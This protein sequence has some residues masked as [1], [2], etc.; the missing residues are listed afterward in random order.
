ML[1]EGATELDLESDDITDACDASSAAIMMQTSYPE[2]AG[3]FRIGE[4]SGH[5]TTMF[6]DLNSRRTTSSM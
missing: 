4:C 2:A 3:Q 6:R 1:V 5:P